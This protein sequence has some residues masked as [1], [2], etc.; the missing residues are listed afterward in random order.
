MYEHYWQLQRNPFANEADAHCFFPA[1][2]HQSCLLKLRYVVENRKGAALLAGGTGLGKSHI[3]NALARQ[4]ADSAGPVAR[5]LFPQLPV[6]EFLRYLA[7]ELGAL[8][9]QPAQPPAGT[10]DVV[11]GIE[12]RLNH[13]RQEGRSPVIIVDEAHL[14]D[15]LRVF[16]ALRLLLNFGEQG[17]PLFTLLLV[18]QPELLVMVR[19]LGQLEDRLAVKCV[20]R[21][22]SATETA[23]YVTCRLEAAGGSGQLFEPDALSVIAEMSGGV[24]RRINRLCDMALLV[25]YADES[26]S[27]T[28]EQV[29]AVAE[30]LSS[31]SAD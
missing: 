7:A 27:I 12:R 6:P 21:P 11:R 4:L 13:W 16:Q 28:P 19:R 22:L 1:E 15:D 3:V 10:D 18:G 23:A 2:S 26:R 14:I 30:E 24:P 8:G 31:V 5:V 25:G 20:L 9:D 29:E 17:S